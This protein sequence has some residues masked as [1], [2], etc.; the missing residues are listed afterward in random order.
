MFFSLSGISHIKRLATQTGLAI[1]QKYH[2]LLLNSNQLDN[3]K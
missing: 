2:I 3:K 1:P